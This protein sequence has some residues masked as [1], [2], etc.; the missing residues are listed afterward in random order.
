MF[1]CN[2]LHRSIA[3]CYLIC[4]CQLTMG[5]IS[6]SEA[7]VIRTV[8]LAEEVSEKVFYYY[9]DEWRGAGQLGIG[10][11]AFVCPDS[12]FQKLYKGILDEFPYTDSITYKIKFYKDTTRAI[13]IDGIIAFELFIVFTE[14]E[15]ASETAEVSFFTTSRFNQERF[16]DQYVQ[17]TSDLYKVDGKWKVLNCR[18]KPIK[19]TKYVK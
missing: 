2:K 10:T 3:I 16:R 11:F 1:L 9:E 6:D 14:I 18:I 15:I 7:I 19:W 12:T 5:Q 8:L 4:C 13:F 17:V